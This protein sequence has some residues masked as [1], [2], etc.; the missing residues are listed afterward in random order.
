MR[1]PEDETQRIR[2]RLANDNEYELI[3]DRRIRQTH[4]DEE[5]G[6]E[7]GSRRRSERR[8]RR[9]SRSR[10]TTLDS[11][12]R[13]KRKSAA[14]RGQCVRRVP[15][16]HTPD[17][18]DPTRILR[19]VPTPGPRLTHRR[20]SAR[21]SMASR[22][23]PDSEVRHVRQRETHHHRG[24][25]GLAEERSRSRSESQSGPVWKAPFGGWPSREALSQ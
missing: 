17:G 7:D 1:V 3:A 13:G 12:D 18:F 23:D 4:C 16:S 8:G 21:E 25:P 10:L 2:E 15:G 22:Q 11:P 19:R 9:R 20:T 5:D 24:P 14:K 6:Y